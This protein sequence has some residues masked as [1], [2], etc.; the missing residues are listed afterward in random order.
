MERTVLRS[1]SWSL[2]F[3]GIS[4]SQGTMSV[5]VVHMYIVTG[6]PMHP[7]DEAVNKTGILEHSYIPGTTERLVYYIHCYCYYPL[8]QH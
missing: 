4:T 3:V 6:E 7:A 8:L 5:Y 2:F 1:S